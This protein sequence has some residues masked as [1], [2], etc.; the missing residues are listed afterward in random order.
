MP[1]VVAVRCLAVFDVVFC[2]KHEGPVGGQ[3]KCP[4]LVETVN[5]VM[6]NSI[7]GLWP[8]LGHL[9][10][11][12]ELEL[13]HEVAVRVQIAWSPGPVVEV[14]LVAFGHANLVVLSQWDGNFS[15][16]FHFFQILM[17][18]CSNY[19]FGF[20]FF[21]SLALLVFEPIRMQL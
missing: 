14:A 15:S 21:L 8:L 18:D 10:F 12:L 13:C 3:Q 11:A 6:P 19:S 2:C 7:L 17:I 1:R 9:A 20:H 4:K 16:P 5:S